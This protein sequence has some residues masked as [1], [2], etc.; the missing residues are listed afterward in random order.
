MIL[1]SRKGNIASPADKVFAYLSDLR[2]Y[3]ELLPQDKVENFEAEE[4]SCT[5]KIKGA[6]TIGFKR[7]NTLPNK[8]IHL[9]STENS[10]IDFRLDLKLNEQEG[11]TEGDLTFESKVNPFVKM[12]IEKPLTSLFDH[13]VGRVEEVF[14]QS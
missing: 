1:K 8:S 2:N 12:M 13:M 7:T 3:H 11:S 6:T 9:I 5:F 4:D 10:P 14:S